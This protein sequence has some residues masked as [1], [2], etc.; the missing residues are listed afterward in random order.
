MN[1]SGTGVMVTRTGVAFVFVFLSLVLG[2]S[3]LEP[4]FNLKKKNKKKQ[5]E[6]EMK[7]R[8]INRR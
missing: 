1:F 4:D 5:E 2:P 6:E 7:K 3:V 8:P